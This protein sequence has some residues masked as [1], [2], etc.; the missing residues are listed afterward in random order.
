VSL[1]RIRCIITHWWSLFKANLSILGPPELQFPYT[2]SLDSHTSYNV[3]PYSSKTTFIPATTVTP[4]EFTIV[5]FSGHSGPLPPHHFCISS[6]TTTHSSRSWL[7]CLQPSLLMVPYEHPG[8]IE[9]TGRRGINQ[10]TDSAAAKL[11]PHRILLRTS[12][13]TWDS[14]VAVVASI[15]IQVYSIVLTINFW[16]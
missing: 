3:P 6:K 2:R 16:L 12:V 11:L 8:S 15:N 9:G 7:F 1:L 4:S 5:G 13:Q 10:I 14:F